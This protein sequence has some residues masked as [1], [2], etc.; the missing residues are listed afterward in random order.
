[1]H[2]GPLLTQGQRSDALESLHGGKP[3]IDGG[4]N[5]HAVIGQYLGV[6]LR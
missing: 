6:V 1:M 5:S 4:W 2:L 3:L